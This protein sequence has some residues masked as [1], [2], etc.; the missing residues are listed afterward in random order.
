M[1]NYNVESINTYVFNIPNG[2]SFNE[3]INYF[4]KEKN[5]VDDNGTL[6]KVDIINSSYSKYFEFTKN[7]S[8]NINIKYCLEPQARTE[9]FTSKGNSVLISDLDGIGLS[10]RSK[11][12]LYH[13]TST[14]YYIELLYTFTGGNTTTVHIEVNIARQLPSACPCPVFSGTEKNASFFS[15]TMNQPTFMVTNAGLL[16]TLVK[17]SKYVGTKRIVP[18][19]SITLNAFGKREGAPGGS[20]APPRNMF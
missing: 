11:D 20:G 5:N 12:L 4:V 19:E 9:Q 16:T 1:I 13:N 10:L 7:T 17:T 2:T 14:K 18:S 15:G 3:K 8:N 6:F